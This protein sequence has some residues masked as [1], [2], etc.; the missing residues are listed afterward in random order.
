MLIERLPAGREVAWARSRCPACGTTLAARDLVPL[1]SF[2]WLRGRCR[3]CHG[4]IAAFHPAIELAAVAVAG[5]ATLASGDD[6]ARLWFDCALGWT[7]LALGWI[8]WEH[9][10]LPDVLTL[11]LIPL[12]LLAAA[13]T[14]PP[15]AAF[16]HALA[17]ALGYSAFR[18]VAAGYRRL[19]GQEGLG[20]GDAKLL[21]AGGA[22]LGL[23]GLAPMVLLGA[24]AGLVLAGAQALGGRSVSAKTALPFGTSLAL[25]LWLLR[26]YG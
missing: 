25:G 12:G 2:A 13:W 19:R 6:L 11:P 18:A 5:W 20:E 23:G 4:R 21:A 14:G 16:D 24:V 1:L 15:D 10:L 9:L 26:L 7:L 17:A 3:T 8:D 22:W